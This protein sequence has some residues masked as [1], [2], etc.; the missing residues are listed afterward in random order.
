MTGVQT[1]AL[2]IWEHSDLPVIISMTFEKGQ[3]GYATMMGI[4]PEAAA[5]KL[6]QAGAD[7]IGSNC[8]AGIDQI[9]DITK[10]MRAASD[11]PLWF[12]PNAGLPVLENGK[13]VFKETPEY[14]ASRV[15]AL[16]EAGAAIVGG[17]C[18]T[19]P[20]HLEAVRNV[21]DSL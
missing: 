21:L 17:C 15:P 10:G 2:P 5:E 3:K 12:K 11:K 18:G 19:T 6:E 1:C 20:A 16:V 4:T 9:L 14:M 8:G 13:T 7:I